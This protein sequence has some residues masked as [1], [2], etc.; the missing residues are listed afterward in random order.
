MAG[1]IPPIEPPHDRRTAEDLGE[2]LGERGKH[3]LI[4]LLRGTYTAILPCPDSGNELL[5]SLAKCLHVLHGC[6]GGQLQ[7]LLLLELACFYLL[8]LLGHELSPKLYGTP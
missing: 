1:E 2:L 6:F 8:A 4:G 5:P 3:I 7:T